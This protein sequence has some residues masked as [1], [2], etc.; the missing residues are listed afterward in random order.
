MSDRSTLRPAPV[1]S[2]LA[3]ALPER[4]MT[5]SPARPAAPPSP[6]PRPRPPRTPRRPSLHKLVD[7][8]R[9]RDLYDQAAAIAAC[10]HLTVRDMFESGTQPAPFARVAFYR[11][12]RD[13]GWSY[14]RIGDLVGRN[15][16]TVIAACRDEA[17]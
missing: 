4:R 3:G 7:R 1:R 6:G 8:L 10:W 16:T 14:P 2:A 15:H 17:P 11:Y 9:E 12:L 13:L 5:H